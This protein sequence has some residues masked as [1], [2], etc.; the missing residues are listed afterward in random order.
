MKYNDNIGAFIIGILLTVL[1]FVCLKKCESEPYVNEKIGDVY[2]KIEIGKF[3]KGDVQAK[4]D[5]VI[6]YRDRWHKAKE[7]VIHDTAFHE[8]ISICDT[9]V[10]ADSA[11]IVSQNKLILNQDS[12]ITGLLDVH[13]ED[14][15]T[16]SKLNK[17]LKRQ[18]VL[19]KIAFIAGFGSGGFLGIRIRN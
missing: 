13:R 5:T 12:T 8:I 7:R 19:T 10:K 2:R 14:S 17:K 11:L 4:T 16:I 9:L 15:T 1:V 18:K 3:L 6:K